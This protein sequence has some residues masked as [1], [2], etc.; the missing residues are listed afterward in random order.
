MK[1]QIEEY[2]DQI[3]DYVTVERIKK[4]LIRR[5]CILKELNES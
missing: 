1:I 5:V 4:C 3:V 2:K